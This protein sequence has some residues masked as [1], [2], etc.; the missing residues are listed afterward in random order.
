MD[1][2]KIG[3]SRKIVDSRILYLL[4]IHYLSRIL[5]LSRIHYLFLFANHYGF[6]IFCANLQFIREYTID[7]LSFSRSHFEFTIYFTNRQWNYYLFFRMHVEI[8]ILF[9]YHWIKCCFHC[10]WIFMSVIADMSFFAHNVMM[11]LRLRNSLIMM[12]SLRHSR[13]THIGPKIEKLVSRYIM[14]KKR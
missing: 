9:F 10:E 13:I 2:R 1:S 8:I 12:Y 14:P 3:D 4:R 5:Y 11:T 7:Q 6:M